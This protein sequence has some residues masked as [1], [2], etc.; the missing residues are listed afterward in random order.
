MTT[1]FLCLTVGS[2]AGH[3]LQIA[4]D[5]GGI[6][7]VNATAL[8]AAFE[9]VLADMPA[10]TTKRVGDIEGQIVAACTDGSIQQK[11]VLLLSQ[12]FI[13]VDVAG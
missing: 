9:P 12:M 4:D 11:A 6:V 10:G 3:Q 2:K 8:G 5:T 7:Q 13:Q 1:F